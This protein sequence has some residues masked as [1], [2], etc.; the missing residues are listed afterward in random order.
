VALMQQLILGSAFL[1]SFSAIANGAA[2]KN[3]IRVNN[4][5]TFSS[6]PP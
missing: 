5:P 1:V 6:W 2:T 4:T 3:A